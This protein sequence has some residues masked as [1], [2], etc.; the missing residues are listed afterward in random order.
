MFYIRRK[1][2]EEDFQSSQHREDFYSWLQASEGVK[3]DAIAR[4]ARRV[5]IAPKRTSQTVEN[6]P[7]TTTPKANPHLTL[8]QTSDQEA[9]NLVVN[10]SLLEQ[11]PNRSLNGIYFEG[12]LVNSF[13]RCRV[14]FQIERILN[15]GGC[16]AIKVVVPFKR[17]TTITRNNIMGG[18]G[19]SDT[20]EQ[21]KLDLQQ[22]GLKVEGIK[23][24]S[25]VLFKTIWLEIYTEMIQNIPAFKRRMVN[26]GLN[27][28]P[29]HKRAAWIS[30]RYDCVTVLISG[31]KKMDARQEH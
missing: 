11:L 28:L 30:A 2:D 23:Q 18:W 12:F 19:S 26:K 4:E 27:E 29:P 1:R 9:K 13:D 17:P 10:K 16:F 14:G 31:F 6:L 22:F 3:I 21:L 25:A 15:A 24:Q 8:L 20:I 5:S 7:A